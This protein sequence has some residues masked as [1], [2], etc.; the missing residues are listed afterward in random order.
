M[1]QK[2]MKWA[3]AAAGEI[4]FRH[5]EKRLS[6]EST[7]ALEEKLRESEKSLSLEITKTQRSKA[8]TIRYDLEPRP[9][10][11]RSLSYRPPE[12][13]DNPNYSPVLWS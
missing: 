9:A 8:L 4:P 2:K 12:V 10:L 13:P 5:K 6:H 7:E 11:I 3:Q 1:Q